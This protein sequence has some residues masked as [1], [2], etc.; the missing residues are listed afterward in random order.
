VLSPAAL[1][2]LGQY[3]MVVLHR[4]TRPVLGRIE[5]VWERRDVRQAH[6]VA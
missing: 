6:R 1:R 5:P 3:R 4:T 2:T